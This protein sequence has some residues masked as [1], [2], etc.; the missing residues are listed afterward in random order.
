M[1][2][3][4]TSNQ[5][6]F[7]ATSAQGSGGP[8][9]YAGGNGMPTYGSASSTIG[10]KDTILNNA[11]VKRQTSQ[12]I[13]DTIGDANG[14]A[15]A[16]PRA[17]A[18]LRNIAKN[19]VDLLNTAVFGADARRAKFD[20][21]VKAL[22]GLTSGEESWWLDM[23]TRMENW[24]SD[25]GA[26]FDKWVMLK[27]V[28]PTKAMNQQQLI[29]ARR[30]MQ[31][32]INAVNDRL[33]RNTVNPILKD[34]VEPVAKRLG[35]S[36]RDMAV[37]LGD[38]ANALAVPEK[39]AELLR[40]WNE[41]L[42]TLK[43]I[44]TDKLRRKDINR[45]TELKN[46]INNLNTYI[47]AVDVPEGLVSCGYTNGQAQKL[48]QDLRDLGIT[49]AEGAEFSAR[50]TDW[51]YEILLERAKAGTLDPD[52]LRRF[53]KSYANYV[54]FQNRFDNSLG[55][56]NET[57]TYNPGTYHAMDGSR[58]KPDSAFLTLESYS[59]R[60]A[61]EVGMQEFGI[62]LASKAVLDKANKV[63]NGLRLYSKKQIDRWKLSPN[64]AISKWAQNFDTQGGIVVDVPQYKNG[65]FVGNKRCYVC[66]D[67]NWKD[68]SLD[69]SVINN[70][71]LAAPKISGGLHK[72]AVANSWYGQMF[73]RMTGFF[74]P[75]NCGRDGVER[76]YHLAAMTTYDAM[77]REIQGSDLLW[78]YFS[79]FPEVGAQLR[80]AIAGRLQPGTKYGDYWQEFQAMGAFQEYTPG[81]MESGR[82]MSEIIAAQNQ[83]NRIKNALNKQQNAK[84]RR[85][86]AEA[87][88]NK[89][90]VLN[91]ID[92]WN[93]YFNNIAP[94]A[95]FVTLRE[96]GVPAERAGANVLE[97]M[98]MTR[99]GTLTP[100]LQ[101]FFPFV[102]PT[103]NSA[104]AMARSLGLVY[105]PRGFIAAGKNG[106]KYMLGTTMAYAMLQPL[107]ADS[108]DEDPETGMKRIDTLP[109]SELAR[110]VPVSIGDGNYIK[111]PLGFGPIQLATTL[112]NGVDR[113]MR[114][115]M[116]PED[117][118]FE[119]LFSVA[120]N[121]MPGN[122]PEFK[123]TEDPIDYM[124][125]MF[126]PSF[127]SGFTQIATN[128]TH[129]G[130]PIIYADENDE[131]RALAD[132]G[133]TSTPPVYH[134]AAR[135]ILQVTGMDF[136]PEQIRAI[137]NS[138]FIGPLR[139]FR[140]MLENDS[141]YK[142]AKE[143]SILDDHDNLL[144]AGLKALGFGMVAGSVQ[145]E[146]RQ[147]F[148]QAA[149]DYERR[150]KRSGVK[151]TSPEYGND[152]EARI[153]YQTE[154]LSEAGFS[155]DEI[156]DWFLIRDAIQALRQG[157]G[158]FNEQFRTVWRL[159]ND[160]TEVRE[161]LTELAN[162][163]AEVYDSV[164]QQLHYY[165]AAR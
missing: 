75:V 86:F 158:E 65:R 144:M 79:R 5:R 134:D 130:S 77:G 8:G 90:A 66:F 50:L 64:P 131:T 30:N 150:I 33:M 88:R 129:F 22:G 103:L 163:E 76:S 35:Y 138:M 109:L 161:A 102:K 96:A 113:M 14:S 26:A 142:M 106:W 151:L 123:F 136:A 44:P 91:T 165:G 29:M 115:L 59:R 143:S 10:A 155:Q 16:T 159:A 58:N 122:W 38:Y 63:D 89:D 42:N 69:G 162:R 49:D 94:F 147:F 48:L 85:Y 4:P 137:T 70:A 146:G 128:R 82:T 92:Q 17:T 164:V 78:S 19:F 157:S 41:E 54:P 108:M 61:N 23:T 99:R 13:N 62:L 21:A 73:T 24:F 101:V 105:D 81:V 156:D 98:N 110:I 53:P 11:A 56:V 60:A 9:G 154:K 45:I 153:A 121:M 104:A 100:V 149:G 52:I 97:S 1:S 71:L 43:Q 12:Q 148:Y 119:M 160:T 132:Q 141:Q 118:G 83:P 47:D 84:L 80:D 72:M 15:P 140:S 133:R 125:Q 68:G 34:V 107:I 7:S 36:N 135:G 25:T 31:A 139:I 93:S 40:R 145:N 124:A 117:V 120:K 87:G 20:D 18:G 32:K 111:L 46:N 152:R 114:G 6:A 127:L 95:E 2:Q 39:N 116:T 57:R 27:A 112:V 51:A 74:S 37:L 67:P 55:A 28:D 126:T 3:C